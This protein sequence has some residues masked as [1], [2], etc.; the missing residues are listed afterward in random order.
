MVR[1]RRARANTSRCS[2]MVAPN[3][4]TCPY[5]HPCRQWLHTAHDSIGP[6]D[7]PNHTRTGARSALRSPADDDLELSVELPRKLLD[8]FSVRLDA[9][10]GYSLLHELRSH[11]SLRPA[12]VLLAARATNRVVREATAV[13]SALSH[14]NRNCLFKLEMSIV[15]MS[16]T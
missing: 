8:G 4:L 3:R 13:F 11:D 16:M 6:H 12:D 2:A 5:A 9:N 7:K 15:S 14:R 1:Y 10:T